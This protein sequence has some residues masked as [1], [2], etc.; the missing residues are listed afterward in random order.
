MAA[1]VEPIF[2]RAPFLAHASLDNSQGAAPRTIAT[3]ANPPQVIV[4]AGA[5]GAIVG[6]LWAHPI[7]VFSTVVLLVFHRSASSDWT[8][9]TEY[10]VQAVT[11]PAAA[12]ARQAVPMPSILSP[13]ISAGTDKKTGI[14]LGPDE[15]LGVGA[16]TTLPGSQELTV[17]AMGGYY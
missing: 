5:N 9:I 8:L 10:Q 16:L 11:D 7:G 3:G 14:L 15:A 4:E 6:D 13:N 2:P 1:N 17:S 12:I